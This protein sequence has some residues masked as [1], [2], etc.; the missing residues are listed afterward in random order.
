L[1]HFKLSLKVENRRYIDRSFFRLLEDSWTHG[2]AKAEV[3][4]YANSSYAI[5]YCLKYVTKQITNPHIDQGYATP[6]KQLQTIWKLRGK[7]LT[8]YGNSI[9]VL[10]W[11]RKYQYLYLQAQIQ[12]LVLRKNTTHSQTLNE[13]HSKKVTKSTNKI[14]LTSSDLKLLLKYTP[15]DTNVN[16]YLD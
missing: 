7:R 5:S 6:V 9:R 11:S 15:K 10:S 2:L 13:Y 8:Y 1:F 16:G 14:T 3:L 12:R 4:K